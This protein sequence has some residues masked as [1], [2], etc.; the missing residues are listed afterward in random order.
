MTREEFERMFGLFVDIIASDSD[1]VNS[2]APSAHLI[3][4]C[5]GYE[6]ELH[7]SRIVWS[8]EIAC[9]SNMADTLTFSL[10][11]RFYDGT[12]IIR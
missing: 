4:H 11:C 7:P 9:L 10:E 3:N 1:E 2:Y 5:G 12:I 6:L 8:H